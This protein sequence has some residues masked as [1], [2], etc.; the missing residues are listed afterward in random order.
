MLIKRTVLIPLALLVFL[1]CLV[2]LSFALNAK[3]GEIK[4]FTTDGCSAFPD[5]VIKEQSLW[6]NCCT[7]HDL[8]YWK[9][10]TFAQKQEADAKLEQ[11]VAN[12]GEPEIAKLMLA[13]V[14][15]GGSAYYPTSYRWAYGWPYLRGYKALSEE[16]NKQVNT[17]INK[18]TL[19]LN[20][21]IKELTLNEEE[22]KP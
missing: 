13:G 10:G 20:T 18:L 5:G 6:L 3:S 8:A 4:P 17:S 15:V 12:V 7:K 9:G 16:E 11:C 2:A 22:N 21:L 14:K 1:A 19:M